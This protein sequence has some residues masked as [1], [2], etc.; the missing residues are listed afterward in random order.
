MIFGG[1]KDRKNKDRRARPTVQR[2]K[3]DSGRKVF[4]F[5]C[6]PNIKAT[7]VKDADALHV[8]I[9][10]LSEHCLQLGALQLQQARRDPEE[11]EELRR[12]LIEDHIERRTI[13]KVSRYDED[14]GETLARERRRRFEIDKAA[15]VLV[16]QFARRF[17]P[18]RIEEILDLGIRTKYAMIN[19]AAPPP[20]LPG[21]GYRARP[22]NVP[23]PRAEDDN[24]PQGPESEA[25]DTED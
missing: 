4:G 21:T 23:K 13:E 8:D 18:D 22:R 15:H 14:A 1:K 17:D 19:G 20:P 6:S 7:L 9:Y 5:R 25:S 12:H 16:V 11:E 10:A 2:V 3:R 24:S